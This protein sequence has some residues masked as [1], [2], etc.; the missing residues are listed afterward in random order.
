MTVSVLRLLVH[1]TIPQIAAAGPP[2]P[3][4]KDAA[5]RQLHTRGITSSSAADA[6]DRFIKALAAITA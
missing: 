1:A 2:P 4:A 6:L 5:A 3:S